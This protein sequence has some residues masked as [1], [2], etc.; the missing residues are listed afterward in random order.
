MDT[1]TYIYVHHDRTGNKSHT[2]SHELNSA[3]LISSCEWSLGFQS[4]RISPST[5][6]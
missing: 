4:Y 3:K 2:L 6:P 1:Y 5:S